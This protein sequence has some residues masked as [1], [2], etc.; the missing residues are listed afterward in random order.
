MSRKLYIVSNVKKEP[1]GWAHYCP[2]CQ[3]VHVIHVVATYPAEK[4]HRMDGTPDNPS[5]TGSMRPPKQPQCHYKIKLGRILYQSSSEHRYR[6][7]TVPLP[8]FAFNV[9]QT[10]REEITYAEET[11][12]SETDDRGLGKGA[13]QQEDASA[14]QTKSAQ[15]SGSDA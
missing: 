15:T 14:V 1:I 6:C 11:E 4:I 9:P 3:T 12:S 5:F 2:A 7:L 13:A 8:E 10:K